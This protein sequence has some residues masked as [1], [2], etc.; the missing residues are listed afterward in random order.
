[1]FS[2]APFTVGGTLP[3]NGKALID[4]IASDNDAPV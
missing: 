4:A 1:M 2:D 3:R